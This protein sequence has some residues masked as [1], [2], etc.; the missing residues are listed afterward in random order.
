MFV[1]SL[2]CILIAILLVILLPQ[3][4]Y[5]AAIGNVVVQEG[6]TSVEREGTELWIISRRVRESL[7]SHL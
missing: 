7:V 3:L 4:S 5:A 1:S 2:R 6:V